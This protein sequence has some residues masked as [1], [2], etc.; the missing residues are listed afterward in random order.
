MHYDDS[1]LDKGQIKE[2]IKLL[3]GILIF[4]LLSLCLKYYVFGLQKEIDFTSTKVK[5]MIPPLA[6]S[7]NQMK[8]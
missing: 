5:S 8:F 4:I 6:K 7:I 2:H 3:G 1:F